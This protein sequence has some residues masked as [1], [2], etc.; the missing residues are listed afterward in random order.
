MRAVIQR[1]KQAGVTVDGAIVSQIAQGFLILL[2]VT[3]RDTEEQVLYLVRKIAGLRVF[4]DDMGKLNL[5][6]ADIAGEVLVVSQFT[7]YGDVRRGRRPSFSAAASP[8]H[9]Y[10]LYAHFCELLTA[11]GVVVQ[12][13][14]FQAHMDVALI[15]DGPVTLWLDTE[16]LMRKKD[17]DEK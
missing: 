3:H 11:E 14:I 4:E 8:D 17:D 13:G 5:G 10:Q 16:S 7:L 6:L 12:Q 2:G 9:A 15:N 1:V